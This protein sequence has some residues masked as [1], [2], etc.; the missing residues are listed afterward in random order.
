MVKSIASVMIGL[1]L[2][3]AGPGAQT[4]PASK[5]TPKATP[6]PAAAPAPKPNFTGQWVLSTPVKGSAPEQ[7]V[8]QDEKTLTT[9][10]A[11]AGPSHKMIYQLDGVERRQAIPGHAS[12]ITMLARAFWE[13]NHIVIVVRTAYSNGA[14]TD[15]TETWSIDKQGRLVID[16]KE[17]ENGRPGEANTLIYTKKKN[18]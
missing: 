14:K 1:V 7:I 5:P 17:L 2:M 18:P 16:F 3:A 12:D 6:K 4:K 8:T 11:A 10:K 15:S 9:E 13:G